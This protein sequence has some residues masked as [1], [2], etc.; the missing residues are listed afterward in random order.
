MT[1]KFNILV[2]SILREDDYSWY[3]RPE[4][5]RKGGAFKAFK[6]TVGDL[7]GL[8]LIPGVKGLGKADSD[9]YQDS[10]NKPAPKIP[11]TPKTTTPTGFKN[12][13]KNLSVGDKAGVAALGTGGA[14][15]LY[16]SLK[17]KEEK[18]K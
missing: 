17:D 10:K 12:W 6:R 11:E 7:T 1:N 18:D 13:Y 2:D 4:Y 9:G 15:L 5:A 16:K 8:S 3:N 14:Y